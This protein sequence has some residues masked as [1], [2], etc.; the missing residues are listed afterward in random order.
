M[1]LRYSYL[2]IKP[3]YVSN[4]RN[5]LEA[6][7]ASSIWASKWSRFF[8]LMI[9]PN[10]RQLEELVSFDNR[11]VNFTEYQDAFPK[12]TKTKCLNRL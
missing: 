6:F 11:K 12:I 10:T 4:M 7:F 2:D 8:F 9:F 1:R 5:Y 3:E